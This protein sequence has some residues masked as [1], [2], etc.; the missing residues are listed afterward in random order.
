MNEEMI[1]YCFKYTATDIREDVRVH[2][3]STILARIMAEKKGGS[4]RCATTNP[5][6]R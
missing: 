2:G 4:C 1:C 5:K 6:G 3:A